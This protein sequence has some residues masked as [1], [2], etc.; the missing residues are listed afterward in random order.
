MN[1]K[2][3]RLSA[4][5]SMVKRKRFANTAG[6]QRLIWRGLFALA[7]FFSVASVARAQC[8]LACNGTPSAPLNV[9]TDEF[10]NVEITADMGL[11]DPGSCTGMMFNI[12]VRT[13]QGF[14][15]VSGPEPVVVPGLYLGQTLEVRVIDAITGNFCNSYM[16]INDM[17]PPSAIDCMDTEVYCN[18]DLSPS[19]V[20]IPVFIDNC[21]LTPTLT[22]TESVF[23]PDCDL[24]PPYMGVITRN[25][26]AVD[27][28]ANISHCTQ[29][30]NIKSIEFDDIV[31]PQ[32]FDVDCGANPITDPFVTG[33]PT[34]N[35]LPL[36]TGGF[37]QFTVTY[38]DNTVYTCLPSTGAYQIIRTWTIINSC[39]NEIMSFQQLI[40]VGDTTGPNITC[41]NNL[42]FSTDP[43]ICTAT[44]ILPP[45]TLSD[46]CS[47]PGLI[48][49][50]V[51]A[52]FGGFGPGPHTNVPAGAHTLIYTATD[53]C[54]NMST[55]QTTLNVVDDEPPTAICDEFTVVS[56]P[57]T[58]TA[59]VSAANLDDGS[60]DN[61]L[62]IVFT[63]SQ[64]GGIT[65]SPF[66]YFDCTDVGQSVTV[67]LNVAEQGN[68]SA[69]N[70]CEVTVNIQD[71][72]DPTLTCPANML[73]DCQDIWGDLSLFGQPTINDNCGYTIVS[74]STI[75][76][77]NCGDGFITRTWTVT[78]NAGNDVSC[79]QTISVQNLTPFNGASINWPL[80]YYL[81]DACIDPDSLYPENLPPYFDGPDFPDDDCAILAVNY[82]DQFFDIAQPAC[83]KIVR[84][85]TVMDWC[86]FDPLN[87][88]G[89][90]IWS[91][92]QVIKVSDYTDPVLTV[93]ADTCV[94]IDAN[95]QW[96]Q[97]NLPPATA[98][99]CDPTVSI[100]HNS[101]YAQ[102]NGAN[103]SGFYPLG[104]TMVTFTAQDGCGNKTT[105][106]VKITVKDDKAPTPICQGLVTE[107][108]D[109][110]V[111]TSVTV[112]A[113]LLLESVSDNCS[114][115]GQI[116]VFAE[117][118]DTN[119]VVPLF[120]TEVVF[121]CNDL[122]LNDIEVWVID[123]AGNAD[124][125]VVTVE[126]QDNFHLCPSQGMVTVAGLVETENGDMIDGVEVY[127]SGNSNTPNSMQYGPLFEFANLP[128]SYDFTIAPELNNDP[129][130]GVTTYDLVLITRH[131]LGIELLDS[132]YKIIAAD[133]NRSGSVSTV[134]LVYIRKVILQLDDE[135]PGLNSWR[136]VDAAYQFPDPANPFAEVFPEVVN[137]NNLIADQLHTDFVG[138]KVGDVNGTAVAND[139]MD[140]QDRTFAGVL[141][142]V[143]QDEQLK[144]GQ[145]YDLAFRAS[146]FR[147]IL[148]FQFT[149]D[150][151]PQAIELLGLEACALPDL[152]DSNFG[153]SRLADGYLTASWN[154]AEGVDLSDEE[155]L[156]L[157]RVE[158]LRDGKLR[159]LIALHSALTRAEA[160]RTDGSLLELSLDFTGPEGASAPQSGIRLFQNRPNPFAQQTV[161]GFYLPQ[162][163]EASLKVFDVTGRL[164]YQ[165]QQL[166]SSGYHEIGIARDELGKAGMHYYQLQTA[167]ESVTRRMLVLD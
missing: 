151:D 159:D 16:K 133:A 104:T 164:L 157:L 67:I 58:G 70:Q 112:T 51:T 165:S 101:P 152:D 36:M 110:G 46:N 38:S 20:G 14:L 155:C 158:A 111:D 125:C 47:P 8:T 50:T 148:G 17:L 60:Y 140:A 76:L 7:F 99:D 39:T 6:L 44:L 89:G 137:Y 43:G 82:T 63:A 161:V 4:N 59:I 130:N 141:P 37:C 28:F 80:D 3:K 30:I 106:T 102:S 94:G 77:S 13:L 90:G 160:Y 128:M 135:F 98:T 40:D 81:D 144:A 120:N 143:L 150:F 65:F 109:N 78:D 49:W 12:E 57:S 121:T 21:D 136:F 83:F 79:T 18:A 88:Q 68:P 52:S 42:V 103:A 91:H 26:T 85:W 138:V 113:S 145:V 95:C 154:V 10:C 100:T 105:S 33:M 132:P 41:P 53:V 87:P 48:G 124:F 25:W 55:C 126:I 166:F 64:N 123:E 139:A 96:G 29:T 61:C 118:A 23:G 35:G 71:K 84:T 27:D 167:T 72:L 1:G 115:P 73:A 92:V 153:W 32:P 45:P 149:L 119:T 163:D 19:A 122:G 107:L 62:P 93:P 162:A 2:M 11:E 34:V 22:Y 86:V 146:D 74:D 147:Q 69:Y 129:S 75:S 116:A 127:M 131:I 5:T 114:S 134:D 108:S 54:G 156:F 117:M 9:S 66:L 56:V 15:I 24:A 31:I 97:V 142:F